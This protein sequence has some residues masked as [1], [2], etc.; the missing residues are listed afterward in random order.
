MAYHP[1]S[2]YGGFTDID[3]TLLFYSRVNALLEE[4]SVVIDYGCGRGSHSADPVD[5]RRE[6]KVLKGKAKTVIGL[7]IDPCAAA[8]PFI[9]SFR[10][11]APGE[12]WPIE[13]SSIDL[14]L[15]DFVLEHIEEPQDF[16]AEAR[17]VLRRAG[18]LCLRT[19]NAWGYVAMLARHM[20]R[21]AHSSLLRYAQPGRAG[22]DVFPAVYRCNS[23]LKLRAALR[24]NGF[25]GVVYGCE[26]EPRYLAF[27]KFA[28]GLGALHQKLAPGFLRLSL[29][30]FAARQ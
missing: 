13:D 17:R 25:D 5:Y 9:D 18:H 11:V 16:F 19:S 30:A 26:A 28:Y 14:V 1:E 12:P 8:N 27:S 2:R 7:D 22:R 4:S 24:R 21:R 15:S 20:P 6:L 23:I 3:G 29:F 10:L